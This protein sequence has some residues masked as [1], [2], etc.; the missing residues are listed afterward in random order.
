MQRLKRTWV[1][2]SIDNLEHNYRQVRA[3]LGVGVRMMAVVKADGYGHGAAQVSKTLQACGVDW[4]GVSNIME[5][6]A[7]RSKGITK[8]ILILGYTPE[9]YARDLFELACTQCIF[10]EAY[11]ERLAAVAHRENVNIDGH[12]KLD[13]G[14][15]RLGFDVRNID[16]L[17][18]AMAR[19]CYLPNLKITGVFTHFAAADENTDHGRYYT[20]LQHRRFATVMAELTTRGF[21]FKDV[22]CCNSAGT[23]FYPE[24]HHSLVRPGIILYGCSPNGRPVNRLSLRPV[25]TLRSVVS[26]IKTVKAG[27]KISYGCTYESYENMKIATIPIG[28]ADGY[29]RSLSNRGY[30]YVCDRVVPIVGRVCMDQIMLDVTGV[31]VIEGDIVTLFGG[32]SPIGIDNIAGIAGTINYEIMCGISRRVERVYI[33]NGLVSEV[34]DYTQ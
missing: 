28:Y 27:E 15:N 24:Y 14:M 34:V 17:V 16:N 30:A 8:P 1:E 13:T 20:A 7:L 5:A 31:N 4:F 26:Y 3:V 19:V 11:A 25:M 29:P 22:H 32:D 18:T 23:V 9:E 33:R 12:I 2:I 6:R 21:I 10:S